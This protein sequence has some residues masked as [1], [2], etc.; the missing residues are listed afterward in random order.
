MIIV[1][2]ILWPFSLIYGGVMLLRNSFFDWGIFP[3]S[4]VDAKIISVGNLSV[5]GTGKTPHVEFLIDA[6]SR[7]GQVAVLLRGYGRKSKGF[8]RVN[9]HT[10]IDLAGDEALMYARRFKGSI[11][12]AVCEKRVLGAQKLLKNNPKIKYIILDD[13]YQHRHIHR[14]HNI[15][16]TEFNKPY[17][18]DMVLPAGRLREFTKGKNRADIVIVTKCPNNL[19]QVEK[20]KF[21]AN[22][23]LKKDTPVFFSAI[24]YGSFVGLYGAEEVE[25]SKNMVLVTGIANPSP[26]VSYLKTYGEVEHINFKDHHHYTAQDID[27][28]HKLFDTFVGRDKLIVTT[29]K[30]AVR[31]Q[32]SELKDKIRE[33]PWV[34]QAMLVKIEDADKLIKILK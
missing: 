1:R 23:K 28:I 15:L 11:E 26:L 33:Y 22:L 25:M 10:N 30:D 4:K 32:N 16:L 13:A 5:G 14:D 2:F 34:Y 31:I 7:E 18:K 3:V 24:D 6:L 20:D 8:L 19:S 17:F 29:E 12:V 21:K 9:E 27:E